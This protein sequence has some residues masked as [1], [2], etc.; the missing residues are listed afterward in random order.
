MNLIGKYK[1]YVTN[2]E[3]QL[4]LTFLIRNKFYIRELMKLNKDDEYSIKVDILKPKRSLSQNRYLWSLLG[5]IA[6]KMNSDNDAESVYTMLI[7]KYSLKFDYIGCIPDAAETIKGLF[8]VVKLVEE[9]DNYNLYKCFYGSSHYNKE[10]MA[11][12]IDGTLQLAYD[13]GIDT[14]YWKGVLNG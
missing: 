3:N 7:E 9:R 14:E 4:E 8:R 11:I 13:C 1:R 6:V 12:L 5:E 10:E 2:E